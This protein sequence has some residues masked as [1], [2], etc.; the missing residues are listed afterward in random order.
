MLLR[1][2][3]ARDDDQVA[4]LD[5]RFALIS[6][7]GGVGHIF[8]PS[9]FHLLPLI[10]TR[11]NKYFK[12]GTGNHDPVIESISITPSPLSLRKNHPQGGFVE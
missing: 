2:E 3:L 4:K 11:G 10:L 7:S 8:L 9:G 6:A 1:S 5:K 12:Q